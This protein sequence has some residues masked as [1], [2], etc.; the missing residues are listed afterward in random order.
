MNLDYDSRGVANLERLQENQ[1][2]KMNALRER[3]RK[4]EFVPI[5][6]AGS[7]IPMTFKS[8][9]GG[10]FNLRLEPFEFEVVKVADSN[11]NVKMNFAAPVGGS[12]R[13]GHRRDLGLIWTRTP[14]C[15]G[16]LTCWVRDRSG[17]SQGS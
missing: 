13:R 17:M 16:S 9:D 6:P 3:V 8:F 1:I 12:R 14:S 10:R 15:G 11:G 2:R 4:L 7:Y 5:E